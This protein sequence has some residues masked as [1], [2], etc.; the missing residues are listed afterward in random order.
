[1]PRAKDH[2]Y[3]SAAKISLVGCRFCHG[4]QYTVNCTDCDKYIDTI[5][6]Y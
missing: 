4:S 1:M 2:V 3:Q 5:V 6:T